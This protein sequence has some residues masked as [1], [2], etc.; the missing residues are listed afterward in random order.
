[1]SEAAVTSTAA[2]R[3]VLV[4]DDDAE[5]RRLLQDYLGRHQF[6]VVA[7]P[8]TADLDRR[9]QRHR[10]D[11]LVLDVMLPGDDGLAVCRRLREGGEQ[12]PI[13]MLTA[14]DDPADRILGLEFGAD[15]YVGKPFEPRELVARLDAVLR[16][17]R[18]PGSAPDPAAEIVP[19][20]EWRFDLAARRL[21]R[22]EESV[23]L[24]SG[25]FA[26]LRALVLHPYEALRRDQLLALA[27]GVGH[28]ANDRAIDVQVSRLRRLVEPDPRTPRFLQT[29]W[30]V[31]YVFVPD[32]P[33][34]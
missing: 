34:R 21:L 15:D 27:R 7:L 5:L 23:A 1:M 3:R 17:L 24:S 22:G 6:E 19:V 4:V 33:R 26:L 11:V 2:R 16:R 8:G 25:E 9:I 30:G 12:L 28:E 20:G 31:G 29:V 32:R 13:V 14:R 18:T 10:P